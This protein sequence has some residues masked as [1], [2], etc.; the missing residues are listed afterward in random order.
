MGNFNSLL[1][2][3]FAP[4]G[5]LSDP[6]LAMLE[7]HY[8][9]LCKWNKKIN[10][11]RFKDMAEAVRLHYCESLFL[12][13][14]L[15]AGELR[16]A[17]VGAGGGFPGFPVAVLR[18]ECQV[19]LVESDQRKAAF[20]REACEASSN[21]HVVA[22]R[23]EDCPTRY[24]WVIARA[25]KSSAIRRIRLAPNMALL[26]SSTG[27]ARVPWGDRRFVQVFHVKL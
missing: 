21:V 3:E 17:D 23:A 26:T 18:S 8:N 2:A 7:T 20:L 1:S 24:D 14:F 9:L 19:D 27:D 25:V 4:Y 6:Q 10:L 16:I 15:P 5:T 22:C 13:S 11:I 12:G